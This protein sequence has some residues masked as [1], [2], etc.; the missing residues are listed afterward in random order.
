MKKVLITGGSG[1]IGANLARRL[2]AD[3]HDVHLLLR[4]AFS[5]WRLSD[6]RTHLAL[7]VADLTR[8]DEVEALLQRVKPAWVFHLAAHGAYSFQNEI[9]EI[10]RTNYLGT[11]VLAQAC[12]KIGVEIMIHAGSSSEYGFKDHAPLETEA[13]EPNS[14]YAATKAAATLFCGYTARA[15]NVAIPTL[16]LYSVYGPYEDPRRLLPT[17]VVHGLEKSW[18]P[19]ASP[20]TSRDFVHVDDAIDALIALAQK[21][22]REPGAIYNLGSGWQTSLRELAAVAAEVF[23]LRVPPTWNSLPDRDWDTNVWV[24]NPT[25][26]KAELGW[27]PKIDL[28]SGLRSLAAWLQADSARLEYYRERILTKTHRKAH[29]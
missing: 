16:R 5:A 27:S 1:F 21:P 10:V 22:P 24:S 3:G 7:H 26:I 18:P 20:E 23:D 8:R 25:K 13:T 14:A 2:L 15:H 4:P 12:A 29:A 17:L 28:H 9:D 11:T 19:L 6:V